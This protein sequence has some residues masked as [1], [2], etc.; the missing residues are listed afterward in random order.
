MNHTTNYSLCQWEA[1]DKIQRVDF[2]ADNAKID[3]AIKA[4]AQRA[5]ALETGKADKAQCLRIVTGQYTGTGV[6]QPI[7]Y[8]VGTRPKVL[9]LLTNNS[10][11]STYS[12]GLFAVEG[13]ELRLNSNGD[14]SRGFNSHVKFDDTGFTIDHSKEQSAVFGFNNTGKI[15]K[16]WLLV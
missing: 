1:D 11:S 5:A 10:H 13:M 6:L 14:M 16:Y 7:H 9:F 4:V 8:H 2:N 3:A 15:Q 12:T